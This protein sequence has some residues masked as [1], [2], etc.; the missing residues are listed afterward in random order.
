MTTI[1]CVI[2]QKST[3]LEHAKR[4]HYSSPRTQQ[5]TRQFRQLRAETPTE[6]E[7]LLHTVVPSKLTETSTERVP[8]LL[9]HA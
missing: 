9:L 4:L 1:R 6:A 7:F 5:Q 3:V 2:I 8:G